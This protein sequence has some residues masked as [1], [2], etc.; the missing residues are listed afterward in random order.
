MR[1]RF[2]ENTFSFPK[3]KECF[4]LIYILIMSGSVLQI[5]C[6]GMLQRINFFVALA[7][8]AGIIIKRLYIGSWFHY[9]FKDIFLIITLISS[10]IV[11]VV[12]GEWPYYIS[13]F[14]NFSLLFVPYVISKSLKKELFEICVVIVMLIIAIISII[15]TIFPAMLELLPSITLQAQNEYNW[16]YN[17]YLLFAC[18]NNQI[19]ELNNRNIGIFWEPG[20][21]AG[22]LAIA[23]LLCNKVQGMKKHFFRCIFVIAMITTQSATAYILLFIYLSWLLITKCEEKNTKWQVVIFI[24]VIL[25]LVIIVCFPNIII[26]LIE[27]IM[28]SAIST[29]L[30]ANESI[31]RYTRLYS[32]YVDAQIAFSHP[33]SV[34]L[35]NIDA[36]RSSLLF[37]LPRAIDSASTNTSFTMMLYYG[38]IPGILYNWL[39]IK[40]AWNIGNGIL[41]KLILLISFLIIINTEPHYLTLFFHLFFFIYAA[42]GRVTHKQT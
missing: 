40:S 35:A 13:Y 38:L 3:H 28:P 15:A 21:Y 2:N 37:L 23:F 42:N 11:M 22:F 7:L 24:T 6:M 36:F 5:V 14:T 31:S 32:L 16:S 18:Y 39:I 34:G 19:G 4:W 12:N 17:F 10:I 8:L 30:L 1:Y 41:S 27:K 25:C 26:L 9:E 20:M 29:K 33:F